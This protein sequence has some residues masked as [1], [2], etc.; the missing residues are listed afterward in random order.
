MAAVR[1]RSR[2]TARRGLSVVVGLVVAPSLAACGDRELL[3]FDA[4]VGGQDGD[5]TGGGG[6]SSGGRASGG[7]SSGGGSSAGGGAGAPTTELVHVLDT[8]ED[9]NTLSN[10]PGGWW[11][12]INDGAGQQELTVVQGPECLERGFCLR[13]VGSG[14]EGWGA[15]LG[16]G[17][18]GFYERGAY[19]T[20]RFFARAGT[21]RAVSFQMLT[22]SGPRF[23]RSLEVGTEWSEYSLRLDQET[24][25]V[26]GA[27]VHLDVADLYELQWFFFVPEPFEFWIDDVTFLRHE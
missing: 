4:G 6:S 1:R 15:A 17:I 8:F 25:N 21:P 7:A 23:I 3:V 20:V 16:V 19:D 5:G 24:V 10:E 11:Y 9:G 27:T 14:F 22:H 26:D 2:A 12:I 18:D 13:T